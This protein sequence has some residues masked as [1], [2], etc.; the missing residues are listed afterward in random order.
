MTQNPSRPITTTQ[1]KPKLSGN[2][3]S[4]NSHDKGLTF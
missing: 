1:V 2:W 3:P 4:F